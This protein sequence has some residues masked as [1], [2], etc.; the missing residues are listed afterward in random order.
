MLG[1]MIPVMTSGRNRR[2]A[3]TRRAV[4][5][6][7]SRASEPGPAPALAGE[8]P[9]GDVEGVEQLDRHVFAARRDEHI[10]AGGEHVLAEWAKEMHVS[11][12]K[13]VDE[14]AHV[15]VP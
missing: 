14:D 9:V 6:R 10:V 4:L 1:P 5:D 11:R 13:D 2:A 8:N 15:E 12:V 7:S 3:R